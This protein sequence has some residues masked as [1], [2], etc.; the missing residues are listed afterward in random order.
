MSQ[1]EAPKL[2]YVYSPLASIDTATPEAKRTNVYGL[3]VDS[4]HPYTL[5]NQGKYMC[6]LKIIDSTYNKYTGD[7]KTANIAK[8]SIFA[9]DITALPFIHHLGCIIRIHRASA[10]I[11]KE[12][13]QL[14]CEHPKS[15]WTVFRGEVDPVAISQYDPIIFSGASYTLEDQ[16]KK[17]IDNLREYSLKLFSEKAFEGDM[18][19]QLKD[20]T[21]QPNDFDAICQV[22][23]LKHKDSHY[24]LKVCDP[25][26][27][28]HVHIGEYFA[29]SLV[30]CIGDIIKLR[31]FLIRDSNNI[32]VDKFS[33][34][35]L[36]PP[37]SKCR[38]E[39]IEKMKNPSKETTLQ[40]LNHSILEVPRVISKMTIKQYHS[41]AIAPLK[42]MTTSTK[43]LRVKGYIIDIIP[44][45]VGQ[46]VMK[47][48]LMSKEMSDINTT[49]ILGANEV[50][51]YR[52][53]L[54]MK[55]DSCSMDDSL[56]RVVLF[57]GEGI[58]KEMLPGAA[59]LL[60]NKE[61]LRQ[62]KRLRKLFLS[63]NAYVEMAIVP[64]EVHGQKMWQI[65]DTELT[66]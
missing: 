2:K 27:S 35:L 36:L 51:A 6:V 3:V 44:S 17:L 57:T 55:D 33:N 20:A 1:E 28:Y 21:K 30:L 19:I 23:G 38:N 8:V 14:N 59:N 61:A 46:W 47:Y 63:F 45:E 42:S 34:I 56:Y 39:F 26:S 22:I 37:H 52:M 53:Q 32:V 7:P 9:K 65:T 66:I 24:V 11:Y 48:N 54:L 25:T 5:E 58:G 29:H 60:S 18:C 62:L 43:L 15:S 41:M 49:T 40:I 13:L 50:Y 16:D 4:S 64:S 10:N 12:S 31:A